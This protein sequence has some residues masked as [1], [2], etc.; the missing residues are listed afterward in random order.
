[1]S[2]LI[3]SDSARAN[4]DIQGHLQ[5]SREQVR[6]RTRLDVALDGAAAYLDV[7]R[8]KAFERIQR[9]NLTVIRSNL[10]LAETRR[11]IGVARQSEVIRWENEIAN[12]RR[13]VIR[14]NAQRNL[15]EIELNRLLNRPLEESFATVESDLDDPNLL[16]TAA[17][18]EPYVGNPVAFDIF[19]DFM[20]EEG[21]ARAP[22]LRELDAA[23][24]SQ[25]R[26]VVAAERAFWAPTVALQADVTGIE[27][28]GV[29]SGTL[30]L[31]LPFP[32]AL[33]RPNGLNWTIGFSAS[34]PV[35]SGGAR[36]AELGRA[37]EVLDERLLDRRAAAERLEQRIRST[38]HQV[39]A[40]Y[41]AIELA[42]LAADAARR[43]Q[44]LVTDAYEQGVVPILDLLDAQNAA[45]VADQVA[46]SVV[47]DYLIDLMRVQRA[48]GRFDFLMTSDEH[49]VFL[50]R[51][52]AFFTAAGY[53]AKSSQ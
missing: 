1:M 36:R 21:L 9:D 29:G 31:N 15:A 43:N 26:T 5:T 30:G 38:L 6:E 45:L 44:A 33:S 12:N 37:R 23:I 42:W 8:A 51:L 2:Q 16:T 32:S 4:V 25:R 27:T 53:Q 11:R 47:Y 24:R 48:I 28:G 19:R 17:Q 39:G 41:A 35:F 40:S 50:K 13:D 10:E 34:V 3:Y 22:E 7:L 14:A 52:E 20:T 46:A 49:Q 18:L